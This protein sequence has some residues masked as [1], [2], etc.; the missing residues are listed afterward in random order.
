MEPDMLMD[1]EEI[2]Y[3]SEFDEYY[4]HREF[5][6]CEIDRKQTPVMAG[7]SQ[8]S[9][10]SSLDELEAYGL[11]DYIEDDEGNQLLQVFFK[12]KRIPDTDKLMEDI[13]KSLKK[14]FKKSKRKRRSVPKKPKHELKDVENKPSD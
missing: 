10:Y 7:I 9:F 8:R 2:D 3:Q 5:D 6:F 12:P 4:N 13:E 14:Q 11:I 1:I